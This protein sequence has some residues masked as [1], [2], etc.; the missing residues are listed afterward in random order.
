VLDYSLVIKAAG[1]LSLVGMAA[2]VMLVV[3]SKK[4]AVEVDPNI[5][6]ILAALP[7]SNCGACGNP[8]CFLA[9]EE[10]ASRKAPVTL[11]TAGGQKVCNEIAGILGIESCDVGSVVATRFCGGGVNAARRY[12]YS[13]L[14]TC[15]AV[16]RMA[17]GDIFC[18]TGCLGYGDC[19]RIC[20]VG[21]IRLDERRLPVIDTETCIG[22][23][24]CVKECPRS[25]T[26]L[27]AMLDA[28]APVVIRCC[29]TTAVRNRKDT[30][31][32]CCIGCRKC[33]KVCP[34]QAIRIIDHC[35][36]INYEWCTGCGECVSVCPQNCIDQAGMA[37]NVDRKTADGLG[38][39]V[40]SA[41]SAQSSRVSHL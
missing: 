41:I 5:Q 35:A 9:A 3:A 6:R 18:T 17:G 27:L 25:R 13:G 19:N 30:C 12:A 39:K 26:G 7:G 4:F 15:D 36:T 28:K 14:R 37:L 1:A 32:K 21:A 16:S 24:L 34:T 40:L 20:P 2:S 33:E 31:T 22:C 8:S 29:S 38:S 11:C 10:L 23:E